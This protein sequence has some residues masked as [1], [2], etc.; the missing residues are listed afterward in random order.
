[1]NFVDLNLFT[2]DS[3]EVYYIW[4]VRIG[5]KFLLFFIDFY[6][7]SGIDVSM[8]EIAVHKI[9]VLEVANKKK[10]QIAENLMINV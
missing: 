10:V 3:Y 4:W 9:S 1:M 7:S 2:P 6:V 5:T 8:R